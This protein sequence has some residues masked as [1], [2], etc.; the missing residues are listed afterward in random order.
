MLI[1]GSDHIPRLQPCSRSSRARNRIH[2][3]P[4]FWSHDKSYPMSLK[5]CG[6]SVV[7]LLFWGFTW[8]DSHDPY[9]VVGVSSSPKAVLQASNFHSNHVRWRIMIE[10]TRLQSFPTFIYFGSTGCYHI[11]HARWCW[12][13]VVIQSTFIPEYLQKSIIRAA[14]IDMHSGSHHIASFHFIRLRL[15]C[16]KSLITLISIT[17]S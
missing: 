5:L 4:A 3:S 6:I 14:G 13:S 9:V 10:I 7:S 2:W 1:K 15:K 17:N 11:L 16:K 12:Y 8:H